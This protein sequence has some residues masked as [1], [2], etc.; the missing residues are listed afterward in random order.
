MKRIALVLAALLLMLAG[1][2]T[3]SK[4]HLLGVKFEIEVASVT[5]G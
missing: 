1:C 5:Q 4:Y 2:K 3:E